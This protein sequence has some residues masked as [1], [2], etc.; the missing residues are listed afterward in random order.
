MKVQTEK[1]LSWLSTGQQAQQVTKNIRYPLSGEQRYSLNTIPVSN[2]ILSVYG[3][4]KT[5]IF[6]YFYPIYVIRVQRRV[7]TDIIVRKTNISR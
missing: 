6:R 4:S 1:R 2:K 7:K 5:D 3:Y